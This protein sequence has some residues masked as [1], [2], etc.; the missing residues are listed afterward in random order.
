M[1]G[2]AEVQA[3]FDEARIEHFTAHELCTVRSLRHV[4]VPPPN[5]RRHI[6]PCA[7]LCDKLRRRMGIPLV[8]LGGYRSP[9]INRRVGGAPRR[10]WTPGSQHLYFRAADLGLPR[11][12]DTPENRRRFYVEAVKL[13]IE[14]DPQVKMGLGLYRKDAGPRLH[15]DAG[16]KRRRWKKR[17][18]RR[19]VQQLRRGDVA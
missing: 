15:I 11:D 17:H 19:I 6:I 3:L 18:V 13:W 14:T 2:L 16:H 9:K 10:P 12:H 7:K 4:E 1:R 8:L 5:L